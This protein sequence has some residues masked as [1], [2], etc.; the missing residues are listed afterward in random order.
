[1]SR[2]PA[3][4][5]RL[6]ILSIP[7]DILSGEAFEECV[8]ELM[9]SGETH[10]IVLLGLWDFVR[11]RG[12]SMYARTVRNASLVLPVSR[13]L[14]RIA[15]FLRKRHLPRH[16]PFDFTVRLLTTLEAKRRS[17]YLIGSRPGTLQTASSNV[18]G[19]FPQLQIV[20]RCSGYYDRKD[21]QNII[22]AIRKASPSLILAGNGLRG[23]DKWLY[24]HREAFAPGITLW[25]G[26]CI[27]MFAGRK[28]RT[29]R[30]L[31]S[32]GL[33]FVPD[34]IRHPW[35]VYRLFA[36]LWIGL[37]TLYHRVKKL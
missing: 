1:V 19:S 4:S 35:R 17:V 14:Q 15:W 2:Q 7:I 12:N 27:E 22:L 29:S 18:R 33:D 11:A 16:L 25:A 3:T 21:E 23:R 37:V 6:S 36:Y 32:K 28:K 9:T 30:E 5:R 24:V 20:G 31:W 34:F 10:Q 13:T 26:P 8:E